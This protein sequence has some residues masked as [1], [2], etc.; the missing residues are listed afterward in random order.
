M[1]EQ[2]KYDLEIYCGGTIPVKTRK[3]Y[4]KFVAGH[5]RRTSGP[6]DP[7]VLLTIA[8]MSDAV[9]PAERAPHP[10][11]KVEPGTPVRVMEEFSNQ[12]YCQGTFLSV[13]E[14]IHDRQLEVAIYGDN[15]T[16]VYFP[17]RRVQVLLERPGWMLPSQPMPP[18]VMPEPPVGSVA[19]VP[20][21]E[22]EYEDPVAQTDI[23]QPEPPTQDEIDEALM[24]HPFF[25]HPIGLEVI[26]SPP[27]REETR[28][29]YLGINEHTGQIKVRVPA[30]GKRK[31]EE[32]EL[33]YEDAIVPRDENGAPIK[34]V[35]E[36]AAS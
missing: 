29:S 36:G 16:K 10:Y 35:L 31:A 28:A 21:T 12:E 19:D 13:G 22:I 2:D 27:G 3:L 18:V 26:V 4:D 17:E 24:K 1:N 6:L 34:N 15:D 11:D 32:F 30:S 23:A 8:V 9:K 7:S 20:D 33:D 14:G 25:H 5:M